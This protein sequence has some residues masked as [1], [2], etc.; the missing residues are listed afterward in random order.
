MELEN[1]VYKL[2]I[3]AIDELSRTETVETIVWN[4]LID[5]KRNSYAAEGKFKENEVFKYTQDQP[6]SQELGH[7]NVK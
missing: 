5:A 6:R 2:P 7:R 1:F 3:P 4:K